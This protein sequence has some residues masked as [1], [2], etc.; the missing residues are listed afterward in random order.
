MLATDHGHPVEGVSFES[1]RVAVDDSQS[2]P[3]FK[4][5][6]AGAT[7]ESLGDGMYFVGIPRGGDNAAPPNGTLYAFEVRYGDYFGATLFHGRAVNE[8]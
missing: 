8:S 1:V 4:D 6:T 2:Q 5:V 7:V 3:S